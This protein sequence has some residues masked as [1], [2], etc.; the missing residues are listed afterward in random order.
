MFRLLKWL[1]ILSFFLLILTIGGLYSIIKIPQIAEHLITKALSEKYDY[2][3]LSVDFSKH[4]MIKNLSLKN[5]M[6]LEDRGLKSIGEFNAQFQVDSLSMTIEDL[7]VRDVEVIGKMSEVKEQVKSNKFSQPKNEGL[8]ADINR[9]WGGNLILK[10]VSISNISFFDTQTRKTEHFNRFEIDNLKVLGDRISFEKMDFSGEK[11]DLKI[12]GQED[13]IYDFEVNLRA[14]LHEVLKSQVNFYGRIEPV[15]VNNIPLSFD[16][17]EKIVIGG[18]DG[19]FSYQYKRKD[20]NRFDHLL[21][22]KD[23]NLNEILYLENKVFVRYLKTIPTN[24]FYEMIVG[25]SQ[26]E[27]DGNLYKSSKIMQRGESKFRLDLIPEDGEEGE[28]MMLDLSMEKVE[29]MH[30]HSSN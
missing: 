3:E 7:T 2:T 24:N 1:F 18:L 5:E 28:E 19:H 11:M 21:L 27:I 4:I 10:K 6:A 25:N 26:I 12:V 16:D 9:S 14:G 8:K 15:L 17:A 29:L 13:N 22:I 30:Q 20:G 23:L